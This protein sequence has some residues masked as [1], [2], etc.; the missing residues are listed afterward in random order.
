MSLLAASLSSHR[1]SAPSSST[2][3]VPPSSTPRATP[4]LSS[5]ITVSNS[6]LSPLLPTKT[7]L[8]LETKV[9]STPSG[10]LVLEGPVKKGNSDI[11]T[12][13]LLNL[14]SKSETPEFITP[15]AAASSPVGLLCASSV[16][17]GTVTASPVI[18]FLGCTLDALTRIGVDAQTTDC[19]NYPARCDNASS[20]FLT[21]AFTTADQAL[22]NLTRIADNIAQEVSAFIANQGS[23]Y[24]STATE[25]FLTNLA[26]NITN[27]LEVAFGTG[28]P[29]SSTPEAIFDALAKSIV[30]RYAPLLPGVQATNNSISDEIVRWAAGHDYNAR[31]YMNLKAF[32]FLKNFN[33]TILIRIAQD[34]NNAYGMVQ[35]AP[36]DGVAEVQRWI[37][38]FTCV[39]SPGCLVPT[40]NSSVLGTSSGHAMSLRT[41]AQSRNQQRSGLDIV[42]FQK[43]ALNLQSK[44]NTTSLR[45]Q[46]SQKRGEFYQ[47]VL[48]QLA[49]ICTL[50]GDAV[51]QTGNAGQCAINEGA[52]TAYQSDLGSTRN[53]QLG[54]RTTRL[55]TWMLGIAAY[56]AINLPACRE[57]IDAHCCGKEKKDM[58]RLT[59]AVLR[60]RLEGLLRKAMPRI[61]V[62]QFWDDYVLQN[63]LQDFGDAVIR[64]IANQGCWPRL[65]ENI[66]VSRRSAA[67]AAI[68]L[69]NQFLSNG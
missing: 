65:S 48:Q 37:N 29:S 32:N 5:A 35:V 13:A 64:D 15:S 69:V 22:Q 62:N 58:R 54:V 10:R 18:P 51:G 56:I 45:L 39:V 49:D 40:M 47:Q 21:P 57:R 36:S 59:P 26:N 61:D 67:E 43:S 9:S 25:L 31:N 16:I 24:N 4:R 68:R 53:H 27:N 46:L 3:L 30:D 41:T 8:N 50:Q 42:P 52:V 28:N 14:P 23:D 66:W 60:E 63:Q 11:Q 19:L 20:T 12:R 55:V 17:I 6:S 44:S 34:M 33:D 38:P 1:F 7:G 2:A